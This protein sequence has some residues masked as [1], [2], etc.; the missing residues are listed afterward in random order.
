VRSTSRFDVRIAY[1]DTV[2]KAAELARV[3]K[4]SEGLQKSVDAKEKQLADETFRSRAP[5]KIVAGIKKTLGEQRIELR[6]LLD[7]LAE[8]EKS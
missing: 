7:R 3:R 5:E 2:D 4:E 8:L 1:A 6:K